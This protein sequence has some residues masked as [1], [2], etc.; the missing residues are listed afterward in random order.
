MNVRIIPDQWSMLALILS[1]GV[2]VG[3]GCSSFQSS[4]GKS[5]PIQVETNLVNQGGL[6]LLKPGDHV[7]V[8]FA[9]VPSP[10]ERHDERI[11]ENGQI[12]LQMI[13][14]IDAAGKTTGQ[15][16]QDI[17]DQFVPKFFQR[18]TVTIQTEN[19]F[20]FVDGEVKNSGRLV[21]AGGMTVL[22]AIA[23]AGG[24]TDFANKKRVL[25]I[26]QEGKKFVVNATKALK[27]AA[28]DLPV[29][30]GDSI[31]VPRRGI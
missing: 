26:R 9:G 13:G 31:V 22:K 11:K 16:Q 15:L 23:S 8:I 29:V 18:L 20:F 1:L 14:P 27:N 25:L 24:F 5:G 21:Y 6:D 17:H 2:L 28:L 10:P 3:P 7:S 4:A 12:T 19:R 30:A